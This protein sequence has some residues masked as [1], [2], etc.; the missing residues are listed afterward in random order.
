MAIRLARLK[1]LL[2]FLGLFGLLGPLTAPAQTP[3]TL[4]TSFGAQGTV[5]PDAGDPEST[6]LVALALLRTDQLVGATGRFG[7]GRLRRISGS[8]QVESGASQHF[9]LSQDHG[10]AYLVALPDGQVVACGTVLVPAD[11]RLVLYRANLLNG[12]VRGPINQFFSSPF[13]FPNLSSGYD[14]RSLD[15]QSGGR[16]VMGGMYTGWSSSAGQVIGPMLHWLRPDGEPDTA[17]VGSGRY[18]MSASTLG[19]QTRII[20]M[21]GEV[22]NGSSLVAARFADTVTPPFYFANGT[23]RVRRIGANGVAPDVGR[24]FAS[25]SDSSQVVLQTQPSVHLRVLPNEDFQVFFASAQNE[26]RVERWSPNGQIQRFG[27]S[28]ITP[29]THG[30][31][32]I[33]DVAT[34]PDGSA[35]LLVSARRTGD[36]GSDFWIAKVL[37]NGLLDPNFTSVGAPGFARVDLPA[38]IGSISADHGSLAIDRQGRIV[39]ALTGRPTSQIGT[40]RPFIQRR[41]GEPMS[42]TANWPHDLLPDPITIPFASARPGELVSSDWIEITGLSAGVRVPL[43]VLDGEY[44]NPAGN[45]TVEP[46]MVAN[47]YRFRLRGRA[48]TTSGNTHLVRLYVGGIRAQRSWDSLGPRVEA[49]FAITAN[50]PELPGARCVGGA[51]N[52]HC[53]SVVPA[54]GVLSSTINVVGFCPWVRRVRVGVDVEA[55]RL[56]D[57]RL[58]VEDPNAP[59]LGTAG[60]VMLLDRPAAQTGAAGYCTGQDLGATF[61][62]YAAENA[63][64][65]RSGSTPAIAGIVQPVEALGALVGR[66]GTGANGTA[67]SG[68]WK[69]IVRDVGGNA[70]ARLRD[71]SIDVECSTDPIPMA[72]LAVAV[73]GPTSASTTSPTNVVFTVTNQGPNRAINALFRSALAQDIGAGW[74]SPSWTC[75]ASAGSS[76][77]P[78]AGCAA[79]ACTGHRIE[80]P[81]DLISG[82]SATITLSATSLQQNGHQ[83]MTGEV[84]LREFVA[85]PGVAWGDPDRGNDQAT[86]SAPV[87]TAADVRAHEVWFISVADGRLVLG[88]IFENSEDFI[89]QPVRLRMQFPPGYTPAVGRCLR[90]THMDPCDGIN[91]PAQGQT[92]V[93]QSVVVLPG[94]VH[95]FEA[96]ATFDPNAAPPSGTVTFTIDYDP[97]SGIGDPNPSNNIATFFIPPTASPDPIFGNGFE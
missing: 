15:Q 12:E 39:T 67:G 73:S 47:G 77:S 54:G 28:F 75:S 52:T 79:P 87:Q 29:T 38:S 48:P 36:A 89:A 82:G 2:L 62:D 6:N 4:D 56:G 32:T 61:A 96:S 43:Y 53:S 58:I 78:V 13:Y 44:T 37:N 31:P 64:V 85:Q 26:I 8:G 21:A 30:I 80:Q 92:V 9:L 7:Q 3:M 74:N 59:L 20:E 5:D 63:T 93:M 25:L 95:G 60:K 71:W 22:F 1:T 17:L 91:V 45:F 68:I 42:D 65:C 19:A 18:H 51:F 41:L 72:D 46:R 11:R 14:C 50:Q 86:W 81:L 94:E 27:R 69:L 10:S 84:S 40:K 90:L 35:L 33:R 88:G 66:P 23:T 70:G 83:T 57:L 24:D 34:R 97:D 55:Q 16:L 76:C 49:N